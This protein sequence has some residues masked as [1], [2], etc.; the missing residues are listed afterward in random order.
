MW[1]GYYLYYTLTITYETSRDHIIWLYWEGDEHEIEPDTI[2]GTSTKQ[3]VQDAITSW[4]YS[5]AD[6]NDIILIYLE[7]HG[8]GCNVIKW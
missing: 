6:P 2:N 3:N 5:N 4:L 8:G 1:D 7:A